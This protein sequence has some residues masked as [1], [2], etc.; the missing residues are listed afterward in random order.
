M[1]Q[2]TYGFQDVNLHFCYSGMKGG[3]APVPQANKDD[4]DGET[5]YHKHRK[6]KN[7]YFINL[8]QLLEINNNNHRFSIAF[9]LI[10]LK[11]L[12]LQVGK[13]DH[14]GDVFTASFSLLWVLGP[15]WLH[16]K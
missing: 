1:Q 16:G 10:V 6:F 8:F 7:T 14:T 2:R 9:V 15:A 5:V 3:Y 4:L 12:I 13:V 11:N